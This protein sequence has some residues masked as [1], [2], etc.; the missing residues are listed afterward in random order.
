MSEDR[1]AM[2]KEERDLGMGAEITRRDFVNTAM[3]GVGASLL[4]AA[5]PLHAFRDL[6]LPTTQPRKDAWFGYGAR[7]DY[8]RASGNTREVAEAAHRIRDKKYAK[9]KLRATD[10][11]ESYD[12]VIVGG[13]MS[14]LGAAHFFQ[15]N[16]A[17]GQTCLI[18]E[19]HLIFGG[20][21][22]ENEFLVG[23][24]RLIAPQ[25]SNDFG[26]PA[27]GTGSLM[28][29]IYEDLK[30]PRQYEFEPWGSTHGPLKAARDNYGHM[31][32]IAE[33]QVDI[34]YWFEDAEGNGGRWVNNM[35]RDDLERAPY[36]PDVRA[37]LLK[38]RYS[39]GENSEAFR[40]KL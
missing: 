29:K 14:G 34:G 11:G 21:A 10:T 40:Q 32:G 25:G 16:A 18:L 15:K 13:G 4:H 23:G 17:A 6:A 27:A 5:A 24:H 37:Q 31:T 22:K 7:G 12:L 33:S 26:P 35:W 8:A 38:W 9:D 39:N 2:A 3:V 1:K 20:E 30:I 19:N 36:S 28:D